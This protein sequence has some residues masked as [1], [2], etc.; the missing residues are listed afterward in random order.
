MIRDGTVDTVRV[1]NES[2]D[3]ANLATNKNISNLDHEMVKD[4][5]AGL[6]KLSP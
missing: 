4:D 2:E 6:S 5:T 3:N 1:L